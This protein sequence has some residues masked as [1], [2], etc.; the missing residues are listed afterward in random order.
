[1][2]LNDMRIRMARGGVLE[3]NWKIPRAFGWY[4]LGAM[5]ALYT[6]AYFASVAIG[7]WALAPSA[8]AAWYIP[9]L[10]MYADGEARTER[11]LKDTYSG[12]KAL[13]YNPHI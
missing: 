3:H 10:A 1:M 8:L 12:I 2:N 13:R 9:V 4:W 11:I 7:W 5:A 6:G